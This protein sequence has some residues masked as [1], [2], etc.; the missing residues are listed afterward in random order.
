M[1]YVNITMMLDN[2]IISSRHCYAVCQHN[3]VSS[4]MLTYPCWILAKYL[5]GV[6]YAII[7]M[8]YLLLLDEKQKNNRILC[9]IKYD[10]LFLC[11][12][13]GINT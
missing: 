4:R 13:N 10:H 8:P 11:V 9:L 5:V 12:L 3:Y 2:I 1:L 7:A 6:K